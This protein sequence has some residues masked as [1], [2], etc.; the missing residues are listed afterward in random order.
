[1]I[2]IA[3]ATY[4]GSKYIKEQIESLICQT[5]NDIEIIICD[6]CSKDNTVE[7]IKEF[8]KKD[9]RIKFY[10]NEINLGF[11]KNFE[12]AI[13]LCSGDFIACCDQDDVWSEDHLEKLYE[14]IGQYD[15]ICGNA[16]LVDTNLKYIGIDLFNSIRFSKL[17]DNNIDWLIYL[18]FN[19]IFQGS[20]CLFKKS[21]V[22]RVLPI[23]ENIK[24]H[25]Y[26]LALCSTCNNGVKY[27]PNDYILFY[28]QHQNNITGNQKKTIKQKLLKI[29]NKRNNI[30]RRND[31]LCY[32]YNLLKLDIN[33]QYR[34]EINNAI[35]Y[36]KRKYTLLCILNIPY[37]CKN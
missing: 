5:F 31:D 26:W 18:F 35:K 8:Q 29:F 36:F 22:E 28:R 13:S 9:S 20:A 15:L 12:K 11:K 1:M 10:L 34:K 25:D 4:N 16:R 6:D 14:N 17:P 21:L 19:N 3:L 23:P 24:F 37:F 32:L 30:K 7:I 2:S 27:L 33:N